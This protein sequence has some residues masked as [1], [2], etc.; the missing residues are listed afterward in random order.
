MIS[1]SEIKTW[2]ETKG[3]LKQTFSVLK[4]IDFEFE[5]GKKEKMLEKIQLKLGKT[6]EEFNAILTAL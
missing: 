2:N 5:D 1:P 4:V 6:K 3:K